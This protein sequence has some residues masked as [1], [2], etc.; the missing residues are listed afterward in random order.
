MTL[1]PGLRIDNSNSTIDLTTSASSSAK[2]SNM[3]PPSTK[4]LGG[5]YDLYEFYRKIKE[6]GKSDRDI[7][8][9]WGGH[10]SNDTLSKMKG[11][12]MVDKLLCKSKILTNYRGILHADNV[13]RRYTEELIHTIMLDSCKLME[14]RMREMELQIIEPASLEKLR[15]MQ[16]KGGDARIYNTLYTFYTKQKRRYPA[17]DWI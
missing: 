14:S 2:K 16:V 5:L 9:S 6:T 7:V 1:N 8:E 12:V 10:P 3:V 11:F 13:E 4:L 17:Y 15:N